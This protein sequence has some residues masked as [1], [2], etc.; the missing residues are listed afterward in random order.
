[1]STVLQSP[2][3]I[4]DFADFLASRPTSGEIIAWHPSD[5]VVA[6]YQELVERRKQGDVTGDEERELEAFVNSEIVLS[7]VKARLRTAARAAS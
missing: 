3:L 4:T 5:A 6:R 2:S 1:M 7:L